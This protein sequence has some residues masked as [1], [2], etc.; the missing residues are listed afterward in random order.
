MQA[1]AITI[2]NV[3]AIATPI[4]RYTRTRAISGLAFTDGAKRAGRTGQ[5]R[6][7]LHVSSRRIRKLAQQNRT[8]R[9]RELHK[10]NAVHLSN[11][12]C[13]APTTDRRSISMPTCTCTCTCTPRRHLPIRICFELFATV[14]P[15]S[16]RPGTGSSAGGFARV[17]TAS[18]CT[19]ALRAGAINKEG[20]RVAYPA[21]HTARA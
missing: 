18:H 11:E 6:C 8:H 15:S 19:Q 12:P 13:A 5:S 16:N 4:I 1:I 2:T 17:Y 21:R 20:I 9:Q 7:G 14:E 3:P 10:Q